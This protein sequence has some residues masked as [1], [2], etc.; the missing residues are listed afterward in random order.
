MLG[1]V[2]L[3][4]GYS[5][6]LSGAHATCY[7]EVM[8]CL[9]YKN[10]DSLQLE[11]PAKV[12]ATYRSVASAVRQWPEI[13]CIKKPDCSKFKHSEILSRFEKAADTVEKMVGVMGDNED[14]DLDNDEIATAETNGSAPSSGC[15]FCIG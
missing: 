10:A 9:G 11:S 14:A 8:D 6:P 5:A 13:E 2:A 1:V 15:S 4:A 12:A 3:V 7:Y